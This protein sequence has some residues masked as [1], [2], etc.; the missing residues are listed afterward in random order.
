MMIR[1]IIRNENPERIYIGDENK[2]V[3]ANESMD[4]KIC[5]DGRNH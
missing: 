1:D 2:E 5:A 3:R 4:Y